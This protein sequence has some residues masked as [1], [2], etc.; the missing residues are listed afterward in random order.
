VVN[1]DRSSEPPG[2][3]PVHPA[4]RALLR[5]VL[6]QALADAVKPSATGLT[7]QMRRIVQADAIDWL[8]GR[9]VPNGYGFQVETCCDLLGVD[10][11]A[12]LTAVL[13]NRQ[14]D[15]AALREEPRG[16]RRI[17]PTD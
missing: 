3:S 2:L 13:D 1:I 16:P 17:T 12:V 5:A 9:K 7:P 6:A 11:G 4:T 10:P 14:L 8:R 15:I